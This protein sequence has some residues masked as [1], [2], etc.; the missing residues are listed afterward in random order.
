MNTRT[1]DNSLCGLIASAL[2]RGVRICIG[3]G[4]GVERGPEME[5]NR[6]NA[7]NVMARLRSVARNADELLEIKNVE[8][9]AMPT[10]E[11]VLIC[12]REWAVT[13]SFNWLSYRGDLD[14]AFRRETG[15]LIRAAKGVAELVQRTLEVLPSADRDIG[16]PPEKGSNPGS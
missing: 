8:K 13:T 9:S 15:V 4:L 5:R 7:R 6:R 12:D 1:V 2:E 11:K 14:S 16:G 10:H 3:Y